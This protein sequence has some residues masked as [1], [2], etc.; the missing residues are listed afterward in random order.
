[1]CI[2]IV[3]P[4]HV[5]GPPTWRK[6]EIY[7][8]PCPPIALEGRARISEWEKD[9]WRNVQLDLWK[10]LTENGNNAAGKQLAPLYWKYLVSSRPSGMP[11][12]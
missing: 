4:F 3:A 10:N 9:I 12:K 1:M 6:G 8:C 11:W 7:L 2:S 5:A